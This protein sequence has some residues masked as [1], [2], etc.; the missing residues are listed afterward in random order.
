MEPNCPIITQSTVH[1]KIIKTEPIDE[2]YHPP[3]RTRMME[4]D[5]FCEFDQDLL[6]CDPETSDGFSELLSD[7]SLSMSDDG[8][9]MKLKRTP[10]YLVGFQDSSSPQS[11]EASQLSWAEV[12][13]V[14]GSVELGSSSSKPQ[15]CKNP[16]PKHSSH[17]SNPTSATAQRNSQISTQAQD[18]FVKTS[19]DD[20]D[21]VREIQSTPSTNWELLKHEWEAPS[22][23]AAFVAREFM[24]SIRLEPQN[25]KAQLERLKWSPA[26]S[27]ADPAVSCHSWPLGE[28]RPGKVG[29]DARSLCKSLHHLP[30]C[31]S[32]SDS[33]GLLAHV[34]GVE[35]LSVPIVTNHASNEISSGGSKHLNLVCL[36]LNIGSNPARWLVV[37]A[38]HK[39][40]ANNL[41]DSDL[42]SIDSINR[43]FLDEGI[44]TAE[45]L[46]LSGDLVYLCP[47]SLYFFQG[48]DEISELRWY[49]APCTSLQLSMAW[50]AY[51][52]FSVKKERPLIALQR[53]TFNLAHSINISTESS[54]QATVAAC[55]SAVV[56]RDIEAARLL[57]ERGVKVSAKLM[58]DRFVSSFC[59]RC[60]SEIFNSCVVLHDGS[61][62]CC[63]CHL[64]SE[65]CRGFRARSTKNLQATLQRVIT[66]SKQHAIHHD[67]EAPASDEGF[68]SAIV[69]AEAN[70]HST[71]EDMMRSDSPPLFSAGFG[72][73]AHPDPSIRDTQELGA[74]RRDYLDLMAMDEDEALRYPDVMVKNES[75]VEDSI[76]EMFRKQRV[77]KICGKIFNQPGNLSRHYVVH[78][79]TR[80]YR[81]NIC[82]KGFTQKSHVKTHQTVH[83]GEKPYQCHSCFKRFSQL[84]HLKSHLRMHVRSG[85]L[86]ADNASA[87]KA[88]R[89][90]GCNMD[91]WLRGDL[92]AHQSRV[93]PCLNAP[94]VAILP[95][96]PA[97]HPHIPQPVAEAPPAACTSSRA[98]PH[99]SA[100]VNSSAASDA[101]A[102]EK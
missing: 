11:K 12:N 1:S 51:N 26:G 82:G 48:Q 16:L 10:T 4:E 28:G 91:F 85:E 54:L 47:G 3:K 60:N 90:G 93:K 20:D 41:S 19:L 29:L 21:L 71:L 66:A 56:H 73:A 18:G 94:I 34:P 80:P 70:F 40:L 49:L 24:Q 84:G 50:D 30:A 64:P 14:L 27:D 35:R 74:D 44:C 39:E 22:S 31:L 87:R 46:Q 15:L 81:C 78:S 5:R 7:S 59:Q 100:H 58:D 75:S 42:Q 62:V 83:T 99:T 102:A 61:V 37:C 96:E 6:S 68:L 67:V 76:D 77:C 33:R 53:L 92:L 8:A 72:T 88:I 101:Q 43:R 2:Y 95:E 25:V 63:F 89:C 32:P 55:V 98:V 52:A 17:G 45:F 97:G 65:P 86:A 13:A 57:A 23:T 9:S 36:S 79:Q 69:G 38:K